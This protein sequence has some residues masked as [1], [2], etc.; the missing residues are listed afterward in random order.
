M[1]GVGLASLT[2]PLRRALAAPAP[3]RRADR[4]LIL[5]L[6]G[7]VRSSAAFHASPEEIYNP[8]GMLP[9]TGGLRLGK[10]LGD[11]I[12]DP[13]LA[14]GGTPEAPLTDAA[15]MLGPQWNRLR[16]PRIAEAASTFSVLGTWNDHRGDH[17]TSQAEESTGGTRADPGVL[18][19]IQMALASSG[20]P[21]A[22]PPFAINLFANVLFGA[23]PGA[24]IRFA[25]I[26]LDD[27]RDLPGRSHL[28][29][30][31]LERVGGR[32]TRDTAMFERLDRQGFESLTGP[33]RTLTEAHAA[34]RSFRRSLGEQLAQPP[35]V[36]DDPEGTLGNVELGSGSVPLTNGMLLELFL[37]GLGPDPS[38]PARIRPL[39]T[40]Q[41]A[42]HPRTADCYNLALGVRLLQ[43]GAPAVV[44]DIH[45]FDL[46]SEELM[47]GPA[48]YRTVGRWWASLAWFLGRLEDP[49][50]TNRAILERTLVVT[51]SEF[52]RNPGLRRGF[53][54]GQGSDHGDS[55]SCHYLAHAIMGA[56][57]PGGRIFGDVETSGAAAFDATRAAE[58]FSTQRF[59]ATVLHA[60]GL[61]PASPDWGFPDAG[62]AI[63]RLWESA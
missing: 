6:L 58:R 47:F 27:S 9:G 42:E 16:L 38:D 53:N 7:G 20:R 22:I 12:S 40:E 10:L 13:R 1:L 41:L 2:S 59:L 5:N 25:P 36:L 28:S 44:V 31:V 32:W 26:V 49:A 4:I 34:Q 55:A 43:L 11:A 23:A 30:G 8:W 39:A 33:N 15:Y 18:T 54:D 60:L 24:T 35:F 51:T 62:P 61:D 46:H 37:R 48:L 52:G 56:G 57:I 3:S 63:T 29:S 45:G 50:D 21:V 19:R 17:T 14:P